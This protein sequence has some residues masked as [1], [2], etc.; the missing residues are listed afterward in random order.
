MQSRRDFLRL[1]GSS[2]AFMTLSSLPIDLLAKNEVVKLTIL[3]TND[4]HS[5]IDPF[6]MNHPKFAGQGGCAQRASLIKEIRKL[7]K[8]VLLLDSG[9]I[10][11]GTPYFNMY[12]GELELKLMSEMGYDAA[13]IGNHDFDNGISGFVKQMPHAT[14]PFINSNYDFSDTELH[15]KVLPYK[16]FEKGGLKI[17]VFGLGIELKGLVDRR[18]YGKTIYNDPV[19]SAA[20]TALLLKKEMKCD[21][22]ICLSHLGYSYKDTKISDVTLAQQSKNIDLILGAH[23]HTFL[24]EPKRFR[25]RD[26]EEILVAQTGWAGIRLGRIDYFFER[27]SRK[28]SAEGA[29]LKISDY[30]IG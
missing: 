4:V 27:K 28:K 29:T 13:T 18:L 9:D 16:I 11:Q 2:A 17:G 12:G 3:H 6:P 24:D 8:N 1:M 7:E 25:N 30:A 22:V 19:V 23:T 26:M 20:Q 10:F 15:N 21:L 5:H 14:F